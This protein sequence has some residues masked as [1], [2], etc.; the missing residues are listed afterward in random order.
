MPL[1]HLEEHYKARIDWPHWL[2]HFG[3]TVRQPQTVFR[4]NDYSIVLQAAIEGQSIAQGWKHIVDPLIQQGLLVQPLSPSI[5][6]DQP[7]Y[8]I[9]PR[10]RELRS[11]VE[12]LKNWL[13]QEV[14]GIRSRV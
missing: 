8:V 14:S 13:I 2:R 9:A 11:D 5:T 10:D 7:F 4:F 1:L 12:H 6:T 3:A